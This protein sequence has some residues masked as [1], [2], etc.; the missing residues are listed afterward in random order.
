[1]LVEG[2]EFAK[3]DKTQKGRPAD[4]QG[5][6]LRLVPVYQVARSVV[7]V[8]P[9]LF[10]LPTMFFSI[11]PLVVLFPA[12]LAFG[13][14]LATAVFGFAAVFAVIADGFVQSSLSLFDGMLTM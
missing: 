12:T 1:M 5:G 4:E 8:I 10:G 6:F 7:I 3:N 9:I 2:Q 13:I 14:Q 11:P